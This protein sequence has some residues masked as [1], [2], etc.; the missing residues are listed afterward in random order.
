MNGILR[1]TIALALLV[2]TASAQADPLT[3]GRL[4]PDDLKWEQGPT[5]NP[6]AILVGDD[7]KPGMYMYRGKFPPNAKV[8]PHFHPD[9]RIVTV[10]SGTLYMGYGDTFDES[11]M[12]M[13]PA[14]SIWTEPAGKTHY[15]WAKDGEVVIQVVGGN[16]PTGT[17]RVGA[18]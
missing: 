18:K 8:M 4:A 17:T 12:K 1:L 15:V 6:R 2:P 16:G 13:L 9:E 11:A 10:M 3:A 14:G 7:R 5:G